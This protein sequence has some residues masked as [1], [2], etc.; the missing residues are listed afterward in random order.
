MTRLQWDR[1]GERFYE[2]GVDRGV[3]YTYDA[4]NNKYN[5]GQTWNGLTTINE[6]P[7]G[8]E[9]NPVYADN[10][11]YL[12]LLSAEEFG[13]TI[14]A[15][16]YP[17]DFAKCDGSYVDKGVHIGQQT[18]VPFGLAYRTL[19]GN[20]TQGNDYGYLIHLVWNALAAPSEKSRNTVNDTPEPT[21]MSWTATTTPTAFDSDGDY[22]DL[23]PT[24]HMF[25][26]STKTSPEVMRAI[27]DLIWGSASSN[28][29]MPTPDEV[30]ELMS[31]TPP[32]NTNNENAGG[33]P[34]PDDTPD[35]P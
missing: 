18:R 34:N 23:K 22:R 20:D 32:S 13:F 26:D 1:V 30:L 28:A 9:A 14:E 15:Y 21:T 19:L 10:I 5:E 12:N 7:S 35:G 27:E 24:A 16:T 11:K 8:A 2:T 25:I 17:E 31:V 6:T 33:T 29:K 3:L 4:A